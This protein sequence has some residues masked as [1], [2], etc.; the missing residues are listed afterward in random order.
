MLALL[1]TLVE[2][3]ASWR[4]LMELLNLGITCIVGKIYSPL[5]LS[6]NFFPSLL[7]HPQTSRKHLL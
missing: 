6:G 5:S 3:G 4:E 2:T 7:A 1:V